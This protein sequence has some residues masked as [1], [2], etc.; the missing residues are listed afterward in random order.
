MVAQTDENIEDE[1]YHT[2]F[3]AFLWSW[4]LPLYIATAYFILSNFV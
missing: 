4:P 3:S 1:E 2:R